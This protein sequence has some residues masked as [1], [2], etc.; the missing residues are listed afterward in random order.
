[1]KCDTLIC[2]CSAS[3]K[4]WTFFSLSLLLYL[5][6]N[7]C[8]VLFIFL[9]LGFLF[10]AVAVT[11]PFTSFHLFSSSLSHPFHS[12]SSANWIWKT[13]YSK[14]IQSIV[15]ISC[16]SVTIFQVDWW[17]CLFEKIFCSSINWVNHDILIFHV[18]ITLLLI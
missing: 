1:M 12:Y 18:T 8:F 9:W 2:S 11:F 15:K 17:A 13:D 5:S 6:S 14:W 10:F 3:W 4:C 7:C 16:N